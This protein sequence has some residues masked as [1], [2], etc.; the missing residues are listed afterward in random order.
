MRKPQN[1]LHLWEDSFLYVTATVGSWLTARSSATLL[2]SVSGRPFRLEAADGTHTR[3]TAALVAPHVKRR[4]DVD[5]CGLLSLNVDPAASAHRLL[6]AHM[7]G[8]GIVPCDARRFGKLRDEFVA[9]QCG[10][11]PDGRVQSLCTAMIESVTQSSAPAAHIDPRVARVLEAIRTEGGHLALRDLSTLAC[12]SPDRLTHVFASQVG[13]SI[14]CYALWTKVR[15]AGQQLPAHR[16]LTEV[17]LASGFADAAHMSRTFQRYFGVAPSFLTN[18]VRVISDEGAS[19]AWG[20][21]VAGSGVP[22]AA[23]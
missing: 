18:Q 6:T 2:V 4:L 3:C 23:P 14:K 9:M 8:A 11:L 1:F 13:V 22:H 15:C 7:G 19:Q 20:R 10:A 5:V 16:S 12:L 17:A 21:E